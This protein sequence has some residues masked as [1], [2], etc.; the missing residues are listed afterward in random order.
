WQAGTNPGTPVAIGNSQD[1]PVALTPAGDLTAIGSVPDYGHLGGALTLLNR[2]T[3]ETTSYRNVVQDQ[4]IVTLLHR[5]GKIYG[6]S[7]IWGGLGIDPTAT[8]AE[9]FVFDLATRTVETS[10]VPVP[11]ETSIGG[12]TFDPDGNLWGM[13]AN[14]L[15]RYDVDSG[16]VT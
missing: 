4:S 8:E 15:F 3:G 10:L 16:E 5:D 6:G 14:Q 9:L 13:T 2:T 1:R 12:L 11:G 7:A